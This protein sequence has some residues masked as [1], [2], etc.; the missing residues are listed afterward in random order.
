[1]L[2]NITIT[3]LLNN[4][5]DKLSKKFNNQMNDQNYNNISNC[6]KV[7]KN[8]L[9]IKP[10]KGTSIKSYQNS[11]YDLKSNNKNYSSDIL[12]DILESYDEFG[13]PN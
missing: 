3:T 10:N 7:L 9:V 12:V 2:V 11:S 8:R 1:M 13:T 5:Y 6:K 4:I